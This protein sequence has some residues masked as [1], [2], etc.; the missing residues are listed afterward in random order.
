MTD[1]LKLTRYVVV[2]DRLTVS[3]TGSDER[4]V[5]S[6]RSGAVLIVPHLVWLCVAEDRREQLPPAVLQRFIDARILVPAAEDELGA[7]V[8]ENLEAIEDH[9]LLYQ[10]VQP[11][12]W[13]QLDCHYCGQEHS[14][15]H[16]DHS[17][18]SAFIER[19]RERLATRKYRHL[20][21][22][23]FG[24]EPLAGLG[25]MRSLSARAEAL[26]REF[27][28]TYSAQ[29]VTNGLALTAEVA[30]ELVEQLHIDEAEVTLDGLAAD[31]DR[32]RFT[33]GGNG[34]F[35]RIFRNL[36]AVAAA[37][38]LGI[39]I[40]CNVDRSNVEGVAPLIEA[41]AEAGLAE[42]VAF[43]TSPVYSWGNDADRGSLGKSEYAEYEMEWFA[44]QFRLGFTLALIPPRRKIVCMSVQRDAEVVDAFGTTY[45]CTEAPYVPAYGTPN[46]YQIGASGGRRAPGLTA[47]PPAAA[48]RLRG[49]NE[50]LLAR[51]HA[52]CGECPMLPVCGGH[53]PKAWFE[54]HEPCPSAKTNMRQRLNFLYALREMGA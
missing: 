47:P 36:R 10:V 6:T 37:T 7:I 18:Q 29:I 12:A 27:D 25:A 22:G 16:L 54:G 31:H 35:D 50:Q 53:C 44:L 9:E 4:V 21:I 20:K 40:R 17:G 13:C 5:F 11:T 28:C 26:A 8:R 30:R 14:A 23:W 2:S 52:S 41:L 42:R 32:R 48:E 15:Q 33:K 38:E 3:R 24:A 43:Y 46:L 49:F 45:N 1:G 51:E 39:K 19:V 34:S